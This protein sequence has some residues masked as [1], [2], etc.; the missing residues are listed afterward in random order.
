MPARTPFARIPTTRAVA[1]GAVSVLALAGMFVSVGWRSADTWAST[2]PVDAAP[3]QDDG[4]ATVRG[5][6]LTYRGIEPVERLTGS[7]GDPAVAPEGWTIWVASFDVTGADEDTMFGVETSV[8]ASDGAIYTRSDVIGYDGEPEAGWLGG[9]F[10]DES[11]PRIDAV[12][13][14]EGVEPERVRVVPTDVR[15]DYWSFDA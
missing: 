9:L 15:R 12:L 7:Y 10:L 14:P 11:G 4:A 6:T 5:V 3:V 2:H 8:I 1:A 13:L